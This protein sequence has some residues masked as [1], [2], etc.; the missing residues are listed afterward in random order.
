MQSVSEVSQVR[1]VRKMVFGQNA[2]KQ[3]LIHIGGRGTKDQIVAELAKMDVAESLSKTV[4]DRLNKM[5]K[6][7]EVDKAMINRELV[8]S[9]AGMSFPSP[10]IPVTPATPTKPKICNVYG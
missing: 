7:G 4:T 10:V 1:Q 3:A 8:Y 2:V 9:L 6:W 5:H